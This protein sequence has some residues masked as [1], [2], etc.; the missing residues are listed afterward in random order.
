MIESIP[1][2][3]TEIKQHQEN[4]KNQQP[5]QQKVRKIEEISKTG[6]IDWN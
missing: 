4:K 6:E 3:A 5:E 1:V 2:V